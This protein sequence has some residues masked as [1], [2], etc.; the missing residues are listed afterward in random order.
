MALA[1]TTRVHGPSAALGR[2][3]RSNT[4]RPQRAAAPCRAAAARMIAP[5]AFYCNNPRMYYGP[6]PDEA[7]RLMKEFMAELNANGGSV[8]WPGGRVW[9]GGEGFGDTCADEGT[10]GE[11]AAG[12]ADA[13]RSAAPAFRLP[14]DLVKEVCGGVRAVFWLE[15]ARLHVHACAPPA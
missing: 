5:R 9:W 3:S 4:S 11:G 15:A 13:T 10:G 8:A 1:I 6:G 7:R 14:V 12:A 2:G